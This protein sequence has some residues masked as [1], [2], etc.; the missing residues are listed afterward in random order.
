MSRVVAHVVARNVDYSV[1][2]LAKELGLGARRVDAMFR[3][4]V[5]LSPK[6]LLRIFRFQRALGLR[7]T[8]PS[9]SWATIALRAGYYDQAHLVRDARAIAGAAPTAL[10]L[11]PGGG[12]LTEIFLAKDALFC[13]K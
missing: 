1:R 10:L 3:D 9:V 4:H 12:G 8:L 11:H 6:Q 2:G 13:E 5:G 7:R